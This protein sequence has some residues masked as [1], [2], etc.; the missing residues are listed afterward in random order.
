MNIVFAGTPAFAV[1]TLRA[2]V[3]HGHAVAAVLSQPSRPAGRGR[4]VRASAVKQAAVELG[5]PVYEPERLHAS[6]LS[7]VAGLRPE[8][9]VVAAYGLILP[10]ALLAIPARGAINVH[11][12][13]LPRWR[14]AAPIARAIEAGDALTGVSIMQIVPKLDSGP[15]LAQ[16]SLPIEESDTAGTLEERL[17]QAGAKLLVQTLAALAAGSLEP[18]PQDEAAACYAPKIRK[19]EALLDWSRPAAEL[20]RR[21]RAFN[22]RPVAHTG[23]RGQRLRVWEAER[24][25]TPLSASRAAPGTVLATRQEGIAVQTGEGVL[26]LTR[27]Q[28]EGGKI[29]TAAQFLNGHRLRVGERLA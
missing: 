8:L 5:V 25:P 23:W 6:A 28:L 1:P 20:W 29:L 3:A 27:L 15:I 17:A 16:L 10:A 9:L 24:P 19:E 14:G 7:L 22:P 26:Q 4:R 21:V 13:L 2:V 12:S 18:R 11:A